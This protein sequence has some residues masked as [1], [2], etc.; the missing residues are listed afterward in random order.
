LK[1]V[2]VANRLESLTLFAIYTIYWS[3]I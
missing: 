3:I 2:S 1:S